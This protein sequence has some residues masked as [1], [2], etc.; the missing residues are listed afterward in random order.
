MKYIID[1]RTLLD[2]AP[3]DS[4]YWA[5]VDVF[6]AVTNGIENPEATDKL[7]KLQDVAV[8]SWKTLIGA[9]KAM[10]QEDTEACALAVERLDPQSPPAVLKPLFLAWIASGLGGEKLVTEMASA[11]AS[12]ADL[13]NRITTRIHPI[14]MAAE[15]AEEALRQGMLDHY[16]VLVQRV[17]KELREQKRGDGSLLTIRYALSFL[18]ELD[19]QGLGGQEYFS[20]LIKALGKSDGFC[21]LGMYLWEKD[22][23]AAETAFRGALENHDG[24]FV[25][26]EIRNILAFILAQEKQEKPKI[27]KKRTP[28]TQKQLEL[29]A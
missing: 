12:V 10:Y 4:P 18:R 14:A 24:L 20:I 2:Q 28:G 15:Q 1:P 3:I 13:F 17:L 7:Q 9:I 22:E 26:E 21:V 6:D 25:N 11:S 29:F 19:A 27:T 16:E 23:M 5:L 8:E